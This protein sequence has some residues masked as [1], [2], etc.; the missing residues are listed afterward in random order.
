MNT[1]I[2][3]YFSSPR[4]FKTDQVS[5]DKNYVSRAS[6]LFMFRII[7]QLHLFT[8]RT[9]HQSRTTTAQILATAL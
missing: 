3:I 5:S 2:D 4:I 8:N 6:L 9:N 7:Y 1:F